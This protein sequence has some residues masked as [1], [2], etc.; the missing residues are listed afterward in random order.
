MT[1]DRLTR[2]QRFAADQGVPRRQVLHLGSWNV[3]VTAVALGCSLVLHGGLL[4]AFY[5]V[6]WAPATTLN[7]E[8]KFARG[9]QAT[10]IQILLVPIPDPAEVEPEE[11]EPQENTSFPVTVSAEKGDVG[12]VPEHVETAPVSDPPVQADED[13]D[14]VAHDFPTALDSVAQESLDDVREDQP[15]N[16][17]FETTLRMQRVESIVADLIRQFERLLEL[18]EVTEQVD[19]PDPP[20]VATF[21]EA[22]APP[23]DKAHGSTPSSPPRSG[24]ETG[25]EMLNLPT[26][27]YPSLSRRQGEEG[28]VLLQVEVLSDGTV[29]HITVLQDAGFRR[30]ADAAISAARKGR[31]KPATHDGHPIQSTVRVPFRFVLKR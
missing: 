18:S 1:H 24:V 10:G 20:T 5:V 6:T 22:V 17:T 31:F 9:G 16:D 15:T 29:G 26:P 3:S 2:M 25:I 7:P 11:P 19:R 4:T 21:K 23:T 8:V 13:R 30:L 12:H 28:L 27:R 14:V